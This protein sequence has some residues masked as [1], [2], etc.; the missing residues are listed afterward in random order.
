MHF[1]SVFE[2]VLETAYLSSW[3]QEFEC[4]CPGLEYPS[5]TT[6]LNGFAL[7]GPRGKFTT[8]GKAVSLG[9]CEMS[10]G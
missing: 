3:S 2:A 8:L 4:E 1:K 5:R 7:G 9:F 6:V 10:F